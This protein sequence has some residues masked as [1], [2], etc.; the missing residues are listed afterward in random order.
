[1]NKNK[2]FTGRN[3]FRWICHFERDDNNFRE[4]CSS[5]TDMRED[6]KRNCLHG[7]E[8]SHISTSGI[9]NRRF[10]SVKYLVHCGCTKIL[11]NRRSINWNGS[12]G[13]YRHEKAFCTF[14]KSFRLPLTILI[15]FRSI[16]VTYRINLKYI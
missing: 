14:I 6:F 15:L 11:R 8:I 12:M 13:Q 10:I 2:S 16:T 7:C 3:P 4:K 9:P 1:M 5:L